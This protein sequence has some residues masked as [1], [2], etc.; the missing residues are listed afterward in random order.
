M[1]FY[2]KD[3]STV[4]A[5]AEDEIELEEM[6]DRMAV[7]SAVAKEMQKITESVRFYVGKA[8]LNK[9]MT[10]EE[11]PTKAENTADSDDELDELDRQIESEIAALLDED[12]TVVSVPDP[13]GRDSTVEST[14]M[15]G[16]HWSAG[17]MTLLGRSGQDYLPLYHMRNIG[18]ERM[19]NSFSKNLQQGQG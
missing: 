19:L 13:A 15:G 12:T 9:A 14:V 4:V 18:T 7:L 8:V 6:V 10:L 2:G 17:S 16:I 5:A 3:K 1:S 11:I